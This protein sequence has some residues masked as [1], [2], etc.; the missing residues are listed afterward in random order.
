MRRMRA[1]RVVFTCVSFAAAAWALL[2][3]S[4]GDTVIALNVNVGSGVGF[5]NRLNVN[6]TQTGQS[7]I[8]MDYMNLPTTSLDAGDDAAPIVVTT[9]GA[10]MPMRITLPSSWPSG[11]AHLKVTTFDALNALYLSPDAVDVQVVAQQ[12]VAAYVTVAVPVP[13][14]G[15]DGGTDGGGDADLE[16]GAA[17]DATLDGAPAE[18][19]AVDGGAADGRGGSDGAADAA[20]GG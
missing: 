9:S 20:E 11:T 6:I 15:A 5:I 14:A 4:S 18:S 8:D 16:G 7:A 3:C 1:R 19:G 10:L 2:A 12:A 17:E 13:D